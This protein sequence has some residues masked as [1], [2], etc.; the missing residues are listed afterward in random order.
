MGEDGKESLDA[1]VRG[2]RVDALVAQQVHTAH[3]GTHAFV[4]P[5]AVG[6]IGRAG[7]GVFGGEAAQGDIHHLVGKT[8]PAVAWHAGNADD[9][10]HPHNQ[11]GWFRFE[12]VQQVKH[13]QHLGSGFGKSPL[14]FD[15]AGDARPIE[16]GAMDDPGNR[17]QALCDRRQHRH[18]RI[19]VSHVTGKI[20]DRQ[21]QGG[22]FVQKGAD[23][24]RGGGLRRLIRMRGPT[25]QG[26]PRTGFPRHGQST[27]SR[28][29]PGPAGDEDHIIA[30]PPDVPIFI[31]CR[32]NQPRR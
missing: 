10:P 14:G 13:A 20:V 31:G 24:L 11:L 26:H 8:V 25:H 29:A 5:D 28:D 19:A 3:T 1:L 30:R 22:I 9:G 4:A 12:C 21:S 6:H 18:H 2:N 27:G 7:L 32:L 16:S 17:A 23:L 15:L